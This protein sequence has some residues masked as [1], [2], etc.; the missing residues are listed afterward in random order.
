MPLKKRDLETLSQKFGW[1]VKTSDVKMSV[2]GRFACLSSGETGAGQPFTIS[3]PHVPNVTV[4]FRDTVP[5]QP[6]RVSQISERNES[7][8]SPAW[9]FGWHSSAGPFKDVNITLTG[10]FLAIED[11]D[12]V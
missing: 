1:F 7:A 8:E 11:K 2:F 4:V 10:F 3:G 9:G 12:S 6:H 5:V